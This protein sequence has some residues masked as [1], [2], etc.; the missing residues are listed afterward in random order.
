[1]FDIPE[2][3]EFVQDIDLEAFSEEKAKEG[4]ETPKAEEDEGIQWLE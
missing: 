4:R 3:N 2:K 1:M